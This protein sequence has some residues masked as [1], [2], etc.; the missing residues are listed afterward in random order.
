M[1]Y[2]MNS[3][4][5]TTP[6]NYNYTHCTVEEAIDWLNLDM[7]ESTVGYHETA[8][9][10]TKLTGVPIS[11]RRKQIRMGIGDEALVYRLTERLSD[12]LLKGKISSVEWLIANS[13]IGILRKMR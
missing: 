13:E 11:V 4:V 7:F 5:V 12:P 1:R 2:V 3:A 10:L 9:A 6:G 8:L